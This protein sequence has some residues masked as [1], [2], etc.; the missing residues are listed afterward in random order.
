MIMSKVWDDEKKCYV[1]AHAVKQTEENTTVTPQPEFEKPNQSWHKKRLRENCADND[2]EINT[3][4]TKA[5]IVWK[6]EESE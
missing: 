6:I 4:D 1:N 3:G 5:D 2:I